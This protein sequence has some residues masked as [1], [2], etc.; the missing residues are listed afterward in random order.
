MR[1]ETSY[2]VAHRVSEAVKAQDLTPADLAT[3][4]GRPLSTTYRKL[5]GTTPWTV[6]ELAELAQALNVPISA[7]VPPVEALT[8]REV[9]PHA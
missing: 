3:A 6:A 1:N 2:Q 4:L 7:L 8:T 9:Q 5:N